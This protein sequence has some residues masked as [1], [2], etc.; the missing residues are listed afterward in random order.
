MYD[1]DFSRCR[2]WFRVRFQEHHHQ[3]ANTGIKKYGARLAD[4]DRFLEC[5]RAMV[6]DLTFL[7]ADVLTRVYLTGTRSCGRR[8]V[9]QFGLE[10]PKTPTKGNTE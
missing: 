1:A 7:D 10:V 5:E 2:E 8:V 6:A 3:P 4:A 9:K